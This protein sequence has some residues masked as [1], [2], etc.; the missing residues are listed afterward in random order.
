MHTHPAQ[1]LKLNQNINIF[2]T[3]LSIEHKIQLAI[4]HSKYIEVILDFGTLQEHSR[5]KKFM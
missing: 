4:Q 1:I 3:Y 2:G 5:F